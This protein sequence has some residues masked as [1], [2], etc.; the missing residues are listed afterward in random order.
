MLMRGDVTKRAEKWPVIGWWWHHPRRFRYSY[1]QKKNKPKAEQETAQPTAARFKN[2]KPKAKHDR[3]R[4]RLRGK[5]PKAILEPRPPSAARLINRR[6]SKKPPSLRLR[7]LINAWSRPPY[8]VSRIIHGE[9][10]VRRQIVKITSVTSWRVF[11][12]GFPAVALLYTTG[13]CLVS[14]TLHCVSVS[15]LFTSHFKAFSLFEPPSSKIKYSVLKIRW[16]IIV[17]LSFI[18]KI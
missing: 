11:H 13:K 5:K 18:K 4:L 1:R 9:A 17:S 10:V 7:G 12:Y 16:K 14:R 8:F 15:L 2:N 6:P 3:A